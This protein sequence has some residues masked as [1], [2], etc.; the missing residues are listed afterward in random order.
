MKR[1]AALPGEKAEGHVLDLSREDSIARTSS[2]A[3]ANSI[4]SST[5]R[6][7]IWSLAEISDLSIDWARQF[8]NIR[9]WGA[10]H[11]G[12]IWHSAYPRGRLD[13]A[14]NRRCR[15]TSQQGLDGCSQ[16][17]LGNG[18]PDTRVGGRAGTGPRQ[19]GFTRRGPLATLGRDERT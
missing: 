9:Y 7:K 16:Y 5:R 3:P 14:D 4:I 6:A 17:L 10:L 19:C 1:S 18:R 8:W 15:R 12:E 11:R 2:K 13:R